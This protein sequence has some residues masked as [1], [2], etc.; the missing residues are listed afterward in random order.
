MFPI[1]IIEDDEYF[2]KLLETIFIAEGYQ[3]HGALDGKE[4]FALAQ[5]FEPEVIIADLW[6]PKKE[7]LETIR[8]ARKHLPGCH[9]IAMSGQPMLANVSL[10]KLAREAGADATILKPFLP[11][12]ITTLVTQLMCGEKSAATNGNH[13]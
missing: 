7:G 6:M 12:E 1:L 3:V 9:I 5:K 2:L 13:L 8:L 4:G 10:F 11:S